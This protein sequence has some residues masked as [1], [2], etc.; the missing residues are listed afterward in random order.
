MGTNKNLSTNE[1]NS[2]G[3]AGYKENGG[4]NENTIWG[5]QQNHPELVIQDCKREFNL[6]EDQCERLRQILMERGINKWLLA[7]LK[8]IDLKHDLKETVQ[9][10]N[11]KNE[12]DKEL[13]L[14][15]LKTYERLQNIC[16][17][18]R[19]VEWGKYRHKNMKNNEREIII[20]GRSC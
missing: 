3:N 8:F 10:L 14:V 20:R 5:M 17:M 6:T 19:W 7:R 2:G 18:P 1:N 11:V 4:L 13:R 15:V 16:K 9:K 12:H